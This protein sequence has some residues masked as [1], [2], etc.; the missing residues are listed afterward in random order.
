MKNLQNHIRNYK[1][2]ENKLNELFS[3]FF[4]SDQYLD[5]PNP[6]FLPL[7]HE[8]VPCI[9]SLAKDLHQELSPLFP[10]LPQ[11]KAGEPFDYKALA[12]LDRALG[13]SQKQV[14]IT[15]E[16]VV[17]S[18]DKRLITPLKGAH[19]Q[20]KS[21]HPLWSKACQSYKHDQA[22]TQNVDLG[23]T[24]TPDG[25]ADILPTAQ[26]VIEATGAAF[27]LLTVAKSLPLT[28]EVP[29]IQCDFK[30]GSNIFTATYTRPIFNCFAG[31]MSKDCLQFGPNWEQKLFV[32]KDPERYIAHLRAKSKANEAQLL[33]EIN[34]DSELVAFL[35]KALKERP[36]TPIELL[37]FEYGQQTGDQAKK[38]WCQRISNL[39]LST[40]VEYF[41]A[42]VNGTPESLKRAGFAPVVALNYHDADHL[43]DY[44]K[45]S[46]DSPDSK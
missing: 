42:W 11:F 33:Q 35:N 13:L 43:Y 4:V 28:R 44:E 23:P 29:Y 10:D 37:I 26:A 30:F 20:D 25:K 45:L 16:L 12:F 32:V 38:K 6:S 31:P 14:K 17:L 34:K 2:T 5:Q 1:L 40:N 22:N 18:D 24:P 8:V 27:L 36:K 15:S 7:L 41:T 3:S 46:Q 9:E 39:S 21:L 19:E